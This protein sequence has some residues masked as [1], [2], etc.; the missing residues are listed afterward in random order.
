MLDVL[1]RED[2]V[3][4]EVEEDAYEAPATL[5]IVL[6]PQL[7]SGTRLVAGVIPVGVLMDH[8][9]I[10]YYNYTTKEGYQRAPGS[11][12]ISRFAT[13]IRKGRVDFPTAILLNLRSD[14]AVSA[15]SDS[16]MDLAKLFAAGDEGKFYVVDGQHRLL[17]LKK[18]YE[19][20]ARKI[21]DLQ[22]PFT[23]MLGA[24]QKEEM[25]QFHEVNSNAKSVRTDLAFALLNR[26]TENEPGLMESL[27]EKGHDWQV[28]GQTIVERLAVSS[29]LWRHRIRLPSMPKGE[30]TIPS[31]SMVTS[32]KPVL[33]STVFKRLGGD[34][35]IRVLDAYWAGIRSI[36]R[37]A[38]DRPTEF[39]IQKGIGVV[40]LHA[41]LPEVLEVVRDRGLSPTDPDTYSSLLDDTLMELE[42]ENPDS[43]TVNGLEFWAGLP[44]G[45]AG[46][47]SSSAGRRLLIA[48]LRS[49][50]PQLVLED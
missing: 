31:A 11:P 47:Y 15:V 4:L 21:L 1:K 24:S 35:Q 27:Q 50:L 23:C 14:A 38:F 30:T 44:E 2:G 9:V 45:A 48:K 18:A 37:E 40:V 6:G 5:P 22:I 3:M 7:S 20:G 39:T 34:Q 17:A 19:D 8:Y 49:R 16:S 29:P 10:P 43:E 13:A 28:A 12:R 26:R 46:T 41:I 33:A 42:G 32:L 36:L 25:R